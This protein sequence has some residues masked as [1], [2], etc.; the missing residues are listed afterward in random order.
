MRCEQVADGV[1][2]AQG[3]DVNWVIVRDGTSLTLID[4]GY[5]ADLG[6]VEAS[7]REIGSRPEDVRAILLTHAHI[8]HIG[9]VNHLHDTYGTPV[10]VDPLEVAHAHREYL[11]QA[12]R[13][14]VAK[15]AWQPAVLAWSLRIVR[16]GATKHVAVPSAQAFPTA[17]ALDLPGHP[18]PIAVHGHTSG[19]T[20]YYVP[21]AGAIV[22]GD[23][24]VTAHPT[25]SVRAPQLLAGWFNHSSADATSALDNLEPLDADLVLPGHGDVWRGAVK[26]AVRMAR[27]RA[28]AVRRLPR[29]GLA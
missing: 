13:L 25:S 20:A 18:V 26:D 11:E 8:D 15:H 23:G 9:G 29:A 27:E 4:T 3:R 21:N 2:F 22:T 6:A 24:L 19:H 16:A 5:P 1:F 28:S 17:G 14:D 7:I 12:G 10:Y